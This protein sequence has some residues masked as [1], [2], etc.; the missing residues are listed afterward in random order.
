LLV[1]AREE[2]HSSDADEQLVRLRLCEIRKFGR[3]R[4]C[5]EVASAQQEV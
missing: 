4:G 1:E 5:E 2:R 3:G